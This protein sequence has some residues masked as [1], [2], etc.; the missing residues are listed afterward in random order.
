MS[1]EL[2]GMPEK[3]L[4]RAEEILRHYESNSNE[5]V[6]VEQ[7]AMDF[8]EPVKDPVRDYLEKIDPLNMTPIEALN[9]LYELKEMERKR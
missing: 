2:A 1:L 8:S 6:T 7:M 3:L 9:K 4:K 5:I